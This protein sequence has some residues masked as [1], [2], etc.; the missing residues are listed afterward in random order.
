MGVTFKETKQRK[1]KRMLGLRIMNMIG[2]ISWRDD[3]YGEA[4]QFI[5]LVH[6]LSWAWIVAVMIYGVLAQGIPD[7]I[8]DIKH[9]IKY[10]TVWF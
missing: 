4:K 8:D 3:E 10:D 7:T 9:S 6:P 1:L 2:M 5:R